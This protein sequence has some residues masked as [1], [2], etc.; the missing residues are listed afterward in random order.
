MGVFQI[1]APAFEKTEGRFDGP[2]RF[3]EVQDLIEIRAIGRQVD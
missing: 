3:V 1:K 2:P